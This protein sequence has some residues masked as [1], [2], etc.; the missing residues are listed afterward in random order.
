MVIVKVN[1]SI[2]GGGNGQSNLLRGLKKYDVD[3][4]AIVTMADDGGGS[5]VLRT[6]TGM[7]P[8]GDIRN[9]IV[10][11]S[12][13]EPAM[14]VLMQH[15]FKEG[16]LKDQSFGNLF[17]AALNEIHGDFEIAISKIC[18]ILA[19]KGRVLPVTLDD[20]RLEA[21]LENGDKAEGECNISKICIEKNT[22]IKE[23][24]LIPK[25]VKP[26][27]EVLE[28]LE[29]SQ[30]IIMGPG[31]LYT[32]IIPNILTQGIAKCISET[33][34]PKVYV[35]NI[36]S[37]HGETDGMN[38]VDHVKAIYKHSAQD[39]LN[40]VIVNKEKIPG[41]ILKRY[42]EQGQYPLYIDKAQKN[43]LNA[44]GIKVIE[45]DLVKIK[46]GYIIHDSDKIAATIFNIEDIFTTKIYKI[47]KNK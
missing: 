17:L 38:I 34:S 4:T 8:P 46:N 18:E 29:K 12:E 24:N 35:A 43:E 19:V 10:A 11:L 45:S 20:V 6:E 30:I 37:E 5:G 47:S 7:L 3:L 16:R 26:F 31:S 23:I 27:K 41:S 21:L 22:K 25:N 40:Y 1:I 14:E 9:C 44:M 28:Q 42:K 15:R 39:I 32:S 36:M 2:I 13:A 33:S